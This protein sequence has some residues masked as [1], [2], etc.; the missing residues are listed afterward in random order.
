M[1]RKKFPHY[2]QLDE[3]DCGPTCLQIIF[4]YY[5][6]NTR[7]Q[8]LL[9]LSET[10]REGSSLLGLSEAAE[11]LGMHTV[12]ARISLNQL[13]TEAPLPCI[14]YWKQEHFVVLYKIK[15]DK[16]YVSDPAHGLL[17]YTRKE[18]AQHWIG[19]DADP[20]KDEGIVLLMEPRPDFSQHEEEEK[21]DRKGFGFLFISSL[22][23]F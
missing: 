19:A 14:I 8:T 15:K 20:E 10:T 1:L 16:I 11:K 22:Q 13:A 12:G 2:R 23:K 18:F 17:E 3:K 6:K 5:G 21:P 9:R 7:L 4:K